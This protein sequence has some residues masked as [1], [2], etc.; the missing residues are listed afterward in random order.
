MQVVSRLSHRVN[1]S[2]SE[3]VG[4]LLVQ[5]VCYSRLAEPL[6]HIVT[7]CFRVGLSG[8]RSGFGVGFHRQQNDC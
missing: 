4:R 7:S 6:Y 3:P 2:R 1:F 5:H 8:A